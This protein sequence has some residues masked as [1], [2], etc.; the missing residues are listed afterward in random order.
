M[1]VR[2]KVARNARFRD[3]FVHAPLE[4]YKQHSSETEGVCVLL[5][6][7]DDAK[8][9]PAWLVPSPI[10]NQSLQSSALPAGEYLMS[11]LDADPVLQLV[12]STDGE[13]GYR[14]LERHAEELVDREFLRQV[15]IVSPGCTFSLWI[16]G[17]QVR[18]T[19]ES[20]KPAMDFGLVGLDAQ[21]E[22]LRP[23]D[24][25]VTTK[26]R[27][28][29]STDQNNYIHADSVAPLDLA[30]GSAAVIQLVEGQVSCVVSDRI[31]PGWIHLAA[32][33]MKL[34]KLA[35]HQW[36]DIKYAESASSVRID[37]DHIVETFKWASL[38]HIEALFLKLLAVRPT[39][40]IIIQGESMVGKTYLCKEILQNS[41][42]IQ[43][44][45]YLSL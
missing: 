44:N 40:G 15:R 14:K 27:V 38:E 33:Q 2:V 41:S 12:I 26:I 7:V 21:L 11:V 24:T 29:E 36:V 22:V 10:S 20:I 9:Y 8:A 13:S 39:R 16:G 5:Q 37:S 6:C 17:E 19:V 25:S 42:S 32:N 18:L 31:S 28:R 35:Q 1:P 45:D 30:I 43:R 3:T 4:I 34:L 23:P